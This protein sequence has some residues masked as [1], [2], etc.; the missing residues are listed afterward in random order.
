MTTCIEDRTQLRHSI[1]Y[2]KKNCPGAKPFSVHCFQCSWLARRFPRPKKPK[3]RV[4]LVSAHLFQTP[5]HPP[6]YLGAATVQNVQW[7]T[8]HSIN[9][10]PGGHFH[11]NCSLIKIFTQ[12]RAGYMAGVAPFS[13]ARPY[14]QRICSILK[15]VEL[16]CMQVYL[17]SMM[18]DA[19]VWLLKKSIGTVMGSLT[20]GPTKGVFGSWAALLGK[21]QAAIHC[22]AYAA[23]P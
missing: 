20:F 1:A 4:T 17:R 6:F 3:C 11:D 21:G 18:T 22:L 15:I 19:T 10:Y 13:A 14:N 5:V 2:W 23:L 8:A 16:I 9:N 7:L 12:V